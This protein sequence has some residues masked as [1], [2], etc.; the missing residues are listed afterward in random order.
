MNHS[1][2]MRLCFPLS[3]GK[4]RRIVCPPIYSSIMLINVWSAVLGFVYCFIQPESN[5]TY[6][7]RENYPWQLW[8]DEQQLLS[9]LCIRCHTSSTK[10]SRTNLSS[11]GGACCLRSLGMHETIG[12]A[13]H[14]YRVDEEIKEMLEPEL[15]F[16]W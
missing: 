2:R 6:R 1:K 4:H 10:S 16:F 5:K 15:V 7:Y 11:P 8:T 3:N 9:H 12:I 13:N 14:C